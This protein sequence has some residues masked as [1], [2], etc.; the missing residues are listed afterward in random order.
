MNCTSMLADVL[1]FHISMAGSLMLRISYGIDIDPLDDPIIDIAEKA[2]DSLNTMGQDAP[3]LGMLI[4][5]TYI[6]FN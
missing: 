5:Q 6:D 3:Y 4:I 1:I 2:V